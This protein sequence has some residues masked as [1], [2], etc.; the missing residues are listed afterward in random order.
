MTL[1]P[2]HQIPSRLLLGVLAIG[3][4]AAP[5]STS[6]ARTGGCVAA[7]ARHGAISVRSGDVE[8]CV[9]FHK[10]MPGP[11]AGVDNVRLEVTRSG[12]HRRYTP[13]VVDGSHLEHP[14][15]IRDLDMD[16]V[17]EVVFQ[18]FTGGA[19]CCVEA[20]ILT[21]S[22]GAYDV[23]D[24]RVFRDWADHG[25]TIR[26]L[27][28]GGSPLELVSDDASFD[29]EFSSYA[30]HHSPPQIFNLVH[31]KLQDVTRSFPAVIRSD[32]RFA[33]TQFRETVRAY[34]D[35]ARGALAAYVAD[36]YLL[37]RPAPAWASVRRLDRGPNPVRFRRALAAFLKQQGYVS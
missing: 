10:M 31:G 19:H 23:P 22:P 26:Q 14:I 34:P 9:R 33:L 36:A 27:N 24:R 2:S 37:G 30:G 4:W 35:E 1:E 21:T 7:D 32:Q 15:A 16:G 12:R 3:L 17:P 5:L 20:W 25:F 11:F 28:A 6:A 13:P 8:A 29:Y 18:W